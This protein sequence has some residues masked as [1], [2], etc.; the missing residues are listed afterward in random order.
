M[1]FLRQ[2]KTVPVSNLPEDDLVRALGR[3]LIA[4]ATAIADHDLGKIGD[5]LIPSAF[6][7]I[8]IVIDRLRPT[9]SQ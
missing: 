3:R 9:E 2:E 6:V 7:R 5:G 4:M 8:T 1:S